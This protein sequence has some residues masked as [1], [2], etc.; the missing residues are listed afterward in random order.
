MFKDTSLLKKQ[1]LII[2]KTN[3]NEYE[4]RWRDSY[5]AI[6]WLKA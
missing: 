1:S 5:L 2:K 6:Y 3:L 4:T